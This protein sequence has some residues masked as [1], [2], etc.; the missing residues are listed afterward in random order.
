MSRL[1]MVNELGMVK[2][3][4]MMNELGMVKELGMVNELGCLMMAI[5]LRF[6]GAWMVV[7]LR[8]RLQ[9]GACPSFS[10]REWMIDWRRSWSLRHLT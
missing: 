2:E 3:L 1:G 5:H 7:R 4:G 8:L 10:W 9:M 6:C